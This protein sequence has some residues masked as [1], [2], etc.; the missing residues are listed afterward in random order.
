MIRAIHDECA[1]L[2]EGPTDR[3]V[4]LELLRQHGLAAQDGDRPIQ[5]CIG[6]DE[7]L[8]VARVRATATRR[9]GIVIDADE[10]EDRRWSRLHDALQPRGVALPDSP[11]PQGTVCRGYRDGFV[12]GVWVMPD[13][14]GRGMLE[15]FLATLVPGDQQTCHE[16]ACEATALAQERGARFIARHRKKA[17]LY[18]WLAWQDPPG[19]APGRAVA[20]HIFSHDSVCAREFMTWYRALFVDTPPR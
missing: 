18:T 6:F 20:Q 12:V 4:L 15:H 7:L 11:A 14:S 13:N 8:N 9:L 2:V 5:A 10:P 3:A 19:L 1:L 16:Y 17:E